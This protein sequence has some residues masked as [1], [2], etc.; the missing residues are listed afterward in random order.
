[1]KIRNGLGGMPGDEEI[2]AP[3]KRHK[4][5]LPGDNGFNSLR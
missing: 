5:F 2:I 3:G 4:Q 1:M